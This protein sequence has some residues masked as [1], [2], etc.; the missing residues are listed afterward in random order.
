MTLPPV[1][2]TEATPAVLVT[3]MSGLTSVIVTLASSK[4]ETA[5]PSS[6]V[7]L[8]VATLVWVNGKSW[9]TVLVKLHW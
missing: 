7:P 2:G 4:S 5:W 9:A 8:A 6:S 3:V 1:S